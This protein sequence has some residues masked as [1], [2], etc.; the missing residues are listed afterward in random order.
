MSTPENSPQDDTTGRYLVLLADDSVA[1]GTRELHRVAGIRATST[2]E[3][4]GSAYPGAHGADGLV[5]DRLGVAVVD[6]DAD[7]AEALARAVDEP[8]PIA[9]LEQE[10]RVYAISAT[11]EA[12]DA[13]A[14]PADET[15][16]TW[17]LQAVGAPLSKATGAG[18]RVAVLDTGF[19]AEHPDFAGRTVTT[20]SFV[21]GEDAADGHGHGTHCIGTATGPREPATRPGYG[22]AYQAE[23]FAGKVLSNEG[24]GN[25]GGILAGIAWA[26]SNNCHVVSMSLGA[27][28]R[29]GTPYSTVYESVAARALAQ[30]TLIVA[31]AGND[32]KR[33]N[34][35][36][37]PVGHPANCPS[38]LAVGAIDVATAVGWFSCGT[39][40]K[41]GAVDVVAPG[42]DVYSSWPRPKL[43]NK[44]SG[45]SMATPHVAGIAALIS[46]ATGARGWELWARLA[47]SARRLSLVSTD[48]GAG[49]VLA[50]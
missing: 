2:A 49:L 5:F 23:I 41:I 28:V 10:R 35:V 7:Q 25:D 39:V 21:Q 42:V 26:V 13:A 46:Q 11:I 3:A 29:A 31:A 33:Q 44:I 38:I 24:S 17:G 43:Y 45:T 16:Y 14:P 18:I 48:V 22:L 4:A 15:T 12:D 9:A 30:G 37:A 34:G 8:G 32:S 50:P 40:D 1:A 36:I 6:A 27:T 20:S 19:D 47:Q